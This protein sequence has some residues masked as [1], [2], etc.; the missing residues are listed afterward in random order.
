MGVGVGE[1]LNT[2][3]TA[4]IE[5]RRGMSRL[6]NEGGFWGSLTYYSSSMWS[7]N[8]AIAV[9]RKHVVNNRKHFCYPQRDCRVQ[10]NDQ[11]VF[12]RN[13]TTNVRKF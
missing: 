8:M 10:F 1:G 9:D 13:V 3:E 2:Q 7:G 12:L 6:T 11:C 4:N 5:Q